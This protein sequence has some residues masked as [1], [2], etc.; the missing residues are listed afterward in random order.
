MVDDGEV[1]VGD[2]VAASDDDLVEVLVVDSEVAALVEEE[3]VDDGN[4][5]NYKSILFFSVKRK[6]YCGII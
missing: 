6:I 1:V 5:K 2:Q 3:Q 4:I